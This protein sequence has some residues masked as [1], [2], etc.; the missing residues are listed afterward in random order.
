MT[1]EEVLFKEDMQAVRQASKEQDAA[2]KKADDA[3]STADSFSIIRQEFGLKDG[4]TLPPNQIIGKIKE[5]PNILDEI[6][7]D[8]KSC[9]AL[10]MQPD[11]IKNLK[12]AASLGGGE[13]NT[14]QAAPQAIQQQEN[15][16]KAEDKVSAGNAG[17][18]SAG[19]ANN[20]ANNEKAKPT[21]NAINRGIQSGLSVDDLIAYLQ[22]LKK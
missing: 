5:N 9:E 16:A 4:E 20:I 15:E 17:N 10:N 13:N 22:T 19:N 21:V 6:A 18:P 2:Q 14:A 7:G 1:F 8:E 3:Q 11:Q 12:N